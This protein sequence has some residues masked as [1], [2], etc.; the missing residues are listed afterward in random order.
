MNAVFPFSLIV[1]A[2]ADHARILL[3]MLIVFASAKL[4]AE[5]AERLK[6]PPVVGELLAGIAIGPSVFGWV[7]PDDFLSVLAELGVMF[8]LFRVG[9][10]L[11]DFQLRKIGCTA[12]LVAAIGVVVPFLCGWGLMFT[13][14]VPQIEAIFVGT[15]LVATSVGITARVLASKG[16]LQERA[17]KIILAAAVIDDVLGLLVLAAASSLAK[18]TVNLV[19]LGLTAG[20][21]VGFTVV[22]AQWGTKTM[23]RIVPHVE[24]RLQAAGG[25]FTLAIA[26]LF[27]LSLLA[28]HAGV[29]AIIGAFLAGM[30]LANS[31]GRRVHE[32]THGVTELLVPFFLA[33]IGLHLDLSVFRN[34][35][36]VTL[37]VVILVIACLSKFL[38]CALGAYRLGWADSARIGVGMIP[39]GEVG[40][41]V[42]QIGLRLGVIP[43]AIYGVVVFMSIATT[44]IAP[45]LLKLAYRDLVKPQQAEVHELPRVG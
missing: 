1:A 23:D 36:T 10:E 5:V 25:E 11:K 44:I 15:A 40:M 34:P 4:L 31:V 22:V 30:A 19:E 28:I 16:L 2:G 14:G 17:S 7:R 29:A 33:G 24:H 13:L 20:L 41:V 32:M 9:L 27:S 42:A 6:Q 45:P 35:L 21:A 12:T 26:L 18:G 8:L 39:R 37:G 3:D 43:A 38:G